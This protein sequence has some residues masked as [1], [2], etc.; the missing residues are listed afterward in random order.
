MNRSFLKLSRAGFAACALSVA[1]LLSFVAAPVA[2]AAK[3][4]TKTTKH[5]ELELRS[6]VTQPYIVKKG[7]TLWDIANYFFKQPTQW[8]KVWEQ[9]MYIT[10]PDLI[11][12]GNKIWFSGKEKAKK[13]GGLTTTRLQPEIIVKPVERLEPAV[14]T[15]VV[16]TAL[17]RQDFIQPDAVKAAGYVLDSPDERI[18]YGA[19]DRIYLRFTHPVEEGSVFD[20]FRSTDPVRDPASGNIAGILVKHLGQVRITANHKG[21]SEGLVIRAFEEISRGDRVKPVR[22]ISTRIVP[23]YPKQAISGR[24][25][26]IR[27]HAAEAGQNQIIGIN[28]GSRNGLK[29]GA[30]LSVRKAGRI[31]LDKTSGEEIALPE[32]KIGEIIVLAP[33][34]TASLALVTHSTNPINLGDAVSNQTRP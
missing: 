7:D 25:M 14:D 27:N 33:Q 2:C 32:E 19:H 34:K 21:I 8:L 13:T 5:V 16:V 26:Y 4:H 31:V 30:V 1:A 18:N 17:Q 28:L 11:Y 9:N 29:I 3:A 24:V 15:S 22:S 23:D 12:P 6:G 10:N 20:V